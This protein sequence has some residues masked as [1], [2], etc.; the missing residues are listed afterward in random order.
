MDAVVK[1][2]NSKVKISIVRLIPLDEGGGAGGHVFHQRALA[3]S[4]KRRKGTDR[5]IRVLQFSCQ[6]P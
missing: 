3:P 1:E 2:G 5:R 6:A 4:W